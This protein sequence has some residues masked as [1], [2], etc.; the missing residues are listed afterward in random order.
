MRSASPQAQQY[1]PSEISGLSV[2]EKA[3]EEASEKPE[4][5]R[6]LHLLIHSRVIGEITDEI[7][8]LFEA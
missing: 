8:V 3:L 2:F 6:L 1:S 4:E 5:K 7:R